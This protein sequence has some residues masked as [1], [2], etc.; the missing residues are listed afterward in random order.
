MPFS[1]RHFLRQVPAHTMR[2]FLDSRGVQFQQEIDWRAEEAQARRALGGG[3]RCSGRR[4]GR[5]NHRRF[6]ARLS[7]VGRAWVH[8]SSQR[9]TR[10]G[11]SCE[12]AGGTGE[13]SGSIASRVD[14]R[15]GTLSG[16]RGDSLLRLLHRALSRTALPGSRGPCARSRR[17]RASTLRERRE[18]P[19]FASATALGR[20]SMR[21][22]STGMPTA[23]FRSRSTSRTC[24]ATGRSSTSAG[25]SGGLRGRRRRRRWFMCRRPGAWRP[26]ARAAS[27]CTR[28]CATSSP[29]TCWAFRAGGELIL[30][31]EFNLQRLLEDRL[32]PVERADGVIKAR[33]RRLKLEA[34]GKGQGSIMIDTPPWEDAPSAH[35]FAKTWLAGANPIKA[36]FEVVYAAISLHFEPLPGRRPKALHVALS[37]SGACNTRDFRQKD[38]ELVERYLREWRIIS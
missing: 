21:R 6:R 11:R 25:S 10:S 8:S 19:G 36:G 22:L 3:D 13:R 28:R 14:R 17:R 7:H 29:S 1:Y 4:S 18:L 24:P 12:A 34:P 20:H 2:D 30:A 23:A 5:G 26:S 37:K 33:V 32:L 9:H 27:R 15:R 31:Q 38:R 35:A 16:R